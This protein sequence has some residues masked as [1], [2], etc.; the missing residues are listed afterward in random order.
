MAQPPRQ[1]M[2]RGSRVQLVALLLTLLLIAVAAIL[3]VSF[4]RQFGLPG[5][6]S[7]PVPALNAAATPEH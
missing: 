1:P 7:T 4:P 3:V 6:G 2:D 5:L